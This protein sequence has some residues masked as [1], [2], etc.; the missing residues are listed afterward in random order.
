MA[1]ELIGV[2]AGNAFAYLDRLTLL[3]GVY[4]A[5]STTWTLPYTD[6][7]ALF[8]VVHPTS[9]EEIP[10]TPGSGTLVATGD[11]SAVACLVGKVYE[12]RYRFSEW[13]LKAPNT[14]VTSLQGRLQARTLTLNYL[15]TGYYQAEVTPLGRA[16]R[17]IPILGGALE[18][19]RSGLHRVWIQSNAKDVVVEL[20][21]ES[22]LPCRFATASWEGEYNAR[23][24]IL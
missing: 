8:I 2:G 18:A 20:V 4:A 19:V 17:T 15:N 7:A 12:F 6:D 1:T 23:N 22:H 24:Q 5:G 11:Y 13:G 21:S 16:K 14:N 3:T 9:K 10:T